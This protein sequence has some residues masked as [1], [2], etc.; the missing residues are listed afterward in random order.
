MAKGALSYAQ[1]PLTGTSV[2]GEDIGLTYLE[3]RSVSGGPLKGDQVKEAIGWVVERGDAVPKHSDGSDS[4]DGSPAQSTGSVKHVEL[5]KTVYRGRPGQPNH[6]ISSD[7]YA[8]TERFDRRKMRPGSDIEWN[9]R[10]TYP[11]DGIR[12]QLQ[13]LGR[14]EAPIPHDKLFLPRTSHDKADARFI[15]SIR[16]EGQL[17]KVEVFM[18]QVDDSPLI[19]ERSYVPAASWTPGSE[20]DCKPIHLNGQSPP[21]PTGREVGRGRKRNRQTRSVSIPAKN[22][23]RRKANCA[24]SNDE[25]TLP[26]P[27]LI[28]RTGKSH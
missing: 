16:P 17:L 23:G 11:I 2:A 9:C 22:G 25:V 13:Y 6:V 12:S 28:A 3:D 19:L 10:V 1:F 14:I 4:D 15:F 8:T 20:L 7:V 18:K 21:F 27:M 24:G 5:L 26:P